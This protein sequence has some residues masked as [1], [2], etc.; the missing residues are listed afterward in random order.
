MN[1]RDR[2]LMLHLLAGALLSAHLI[3]AS[4]EC[5]SGAAAY[6]QQGKGRLGILDIVVDARPSQTCQGVQLAPKR[7]ERLA[8][9]LLSL[10]DAPIAA[11]YHWSRSADQS[12]EQHAVT[13]A[14]LLDDGL[15]LRAH[16]ERTES[17][18]GGDGATLIAME[19]RLD[20]PGLRS[21]L[22][23]TRQSGGEQCISGADLQLDASLLGK[24]LSARIEHGE[25]RLQG[26]ARDSA[27]R[28]SSTVELAFAHGSTRLSAD[29]SHRVDVD[30][31]ARS[32]Y[33]AGAALPLR[34][35]GLERHTAELAAELAVSPDGDA[36]QAMRLT[37]TRRGPSGRRTTDLSFSQSQT[38]EQR[39]KLG[40]SRSPFPD[41]TLKSAVELSTGSSTDDTL[42]TLGAE[43][44]F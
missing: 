2:A 21:Q 25:W 38:G 19:T 24:I 42:V 13:L 3:G 32:V 40:I 27:R 34:Y 15:S 10:A 22:N 7:R 16:L 37:D 31:G 8:D 26:P 18:L 29:Y 9:L 11:Q 14:P 1:K 28:A 44:R 12:M 30:T 17:L 41:L 4:A 36:I 20:L 39:T 35:L 33:S 23:L 43:Y 5:P 6:D